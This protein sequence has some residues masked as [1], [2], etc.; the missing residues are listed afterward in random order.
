MALI[1]NWWSLFVRLLCPD[2]HSEAITSRPMMLGGVARQTLHAGQKKLT[3]S[4][5]HGKAAE[6]KQ[7]AA[8]ASEFLKGLIA[9]AEQL[10][11]PERW[12]RILSRIFV[13]F[14]EGRPLSGPESALMSG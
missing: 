3:I 10:T 5:G 6:I 7:M 1:Y 8:V 13:N 4:L 12:R 9:A 2:K 11:Q 14:L